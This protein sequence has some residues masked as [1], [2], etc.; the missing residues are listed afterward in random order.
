MTDQDLQLLLS[1]CIALESLKLVFAL[2][3]EN[4]SIVGH[5]KLKHLN[6]TYLKAD[7][8]VIRDAISLVSFALHGVRD[9]CSLQLSNTPKLTELSFEELFPLNLLDALL[10]GMTSCMR[11]QLR[12]MHLSTRA[13]CIPEMYRELPWVDLV[14]IKHLELSF[15]AMDMNPS[16]PYLLRNFF[17]LVR[18]IEACRSLDKLVIKFAHILEYPKEAMLE[19]YVGPRC[20]LS[21]KYLEISRY[22]GT[23]SQLA[24]TSYL[25]DNAISL[26]K[27]TV[28]A[29][30]AW[31][32]ACARRDFQHIASVSFLDM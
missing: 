9:E 25:I 23:P 20:E 22:F 29:R 7:S 19:T 27:V 17:Q 8:I 12:T 16:S 6:L 1:N 11:D 15:Y 21:P 18:L 26:Q 5:T 14:N 31:E 28:V 2:N 13:D 3:L 30:N 24:F 10:T 4:V 32:S